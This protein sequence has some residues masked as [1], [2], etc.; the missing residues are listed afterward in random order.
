MPN[1]NVRWREAYGGAAS[2]VVSE[3]Y[4]ALHPEVARASCAGT[5]AGFNARV[6]QRC[7]VCTAKWPIACRVK[8]AADS[9]KLKPGLWRPASDGTA[10]SRPKAISRYQ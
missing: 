9:A 4:D 2:A 6:S 7:G 8:N 3:R 1:N 5:L 10:F